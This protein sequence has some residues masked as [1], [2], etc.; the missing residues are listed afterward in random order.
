MNLVV[1]GVCYCGSRY[2]STYLKGSDTNSAEAIKMILPKAY[3]WRRELLDILGGILLLKER[4][5]F[6]KL[7]VKSLLG[8]QTIISAARG[9]AGVGVLRGGGRIKGN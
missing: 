3:S 9:E 2:K 1:L 4:I 7:R 8:Y 5:Y 6:P